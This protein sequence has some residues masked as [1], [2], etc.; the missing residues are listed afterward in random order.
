[1]QFGWVVL[2]SESEQIYLS[3][4]FQLGIAPESLLPLYSISWPSMGV[5]IV[6]I[7]LFP[8]SWLSCVLL[9]LL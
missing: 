1:M 5:F 4:V 9:K 2:V 3:E 6:L 7:L 8:S